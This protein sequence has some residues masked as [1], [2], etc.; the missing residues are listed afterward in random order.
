M[1]KYESDNIIYFYDKNKWIKTS[2]LPYISNSL[3][4]CI[5]IISNYIID[6]SYIELLGES[7]NV[8]CGDSYDIFDISLLDVI[9]YRRCNLFIYG[10]YNHNTQKT[11]IVVYGI[12]IINHTAICFGTNLDIITKNKILEHINNCVNM[13]KSGKNKIKNINA[14]IID[15]II[16]GTYLLNI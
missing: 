3:N 5:D 2:E 6:T 12:N 7:H 1:I 10:Q 15:N 11:R 16:K 14:N 8:S 13:I 9:S 4:K